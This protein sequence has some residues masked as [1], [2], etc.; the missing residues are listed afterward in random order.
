MA[1]WAENGRSP[2]SLGCCIAG[3]QFQNCVSERKTLNSNADALS[4]RKESRELTPVLTAATGT[5]TKV[6]I[7]EIQRAQQN[8]TVV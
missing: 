1:C 6:V 4:R 2:L 3:V 5:Q 8:T 7:L